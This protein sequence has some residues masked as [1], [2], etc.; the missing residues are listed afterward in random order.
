MGLTRGTYTITSAGLKW[1][2]GEPM[3][4]APETL[5]TPAERPEG[6]EPRSATADARESTRRPWWRGL[7]GG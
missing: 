1:I 3:P 4:E 6:T 7:F 5:Q 2:E